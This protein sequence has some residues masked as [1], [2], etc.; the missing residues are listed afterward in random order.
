MGTGG[1]GDMGTGGQGDRLAAPGGHRGVWGW[2]HW[3]G[4]M[5]TE[6]GNTEGD[7]MG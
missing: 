7:T 6:M 5:G 3:D 4:D 2:W 1:R